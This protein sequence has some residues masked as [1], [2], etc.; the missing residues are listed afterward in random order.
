MAASHHDATLNTDSYTTSVSV[1]ICVG[2]AG[3][4]HHALPLMA[5]S[6]CAASEVIGA[7]GMA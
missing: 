1:S 3:S 7:T 6:P 4:L 5:W 2:F